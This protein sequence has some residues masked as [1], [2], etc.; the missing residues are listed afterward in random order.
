MASDPTQTRTDPGD[1]GGNS[2]NGH[3]LQE[4]DVTTSYFIQFFVAKGD[5]LGGT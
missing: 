1:S 3:L 4:T 5:G 2:G